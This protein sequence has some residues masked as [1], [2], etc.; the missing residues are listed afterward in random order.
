MSVIILDT[1][2]QKDSFVEASLKQL[3]CQCLRSK[4]MFGDVA[5]STNVLKVIDLKSSGGGLIEIAR[6][7]CSNDHG[8]MKKEIEECLKFG[9]EITFMCFEPNM[10]CIEDIEHWEVPRFKG[11]V[12]GVK[13]FNPISKEPLTKLQKEKWEKAHPTL[14]CDKKRIKLHGKGQLM[15]QVKPITLMKS[16]KTMCEPNHYKQGTKVNFVFATKE[17][18]GEK[19]L[20]ILTN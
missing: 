18:C 19:I 11:D 1:R 4:L 9:G 17:N 15:T 3:G 16:I 5:L 8:R 20:E 7:R 13:Y 12:W 14:L 6:N 2:N 10:T